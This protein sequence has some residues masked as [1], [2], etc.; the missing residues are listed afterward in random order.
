MVKWLAVL[1]IRKIARFVKLSILKNRHPV[2]YT[3]KLPSFPFNCAG[4]RS[5]NQSFGRKNNWAGKVCQETLKQVRNEGSL[6]MKKERLQELLIAHSGSILENFWGLKNF[7]IPAKPLQRIQ[8]EFP[9]SLIFR[10]NMLHSGLSHW[11]ISFCTLCVA[12]S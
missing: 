8:P 9:H 3:L 6:N 7:V 1:K 12:N 11:G 10:G 2:H 4:A 5:K